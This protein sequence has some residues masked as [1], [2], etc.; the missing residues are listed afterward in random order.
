MK[1]LLFTLATLSGLSFNAFATNSGSTPIPPVPAQ[2]AADAAT[3]QA[4]NALL[5]VG[6]VQAAPVYVGSKSIQPLV[7]SG[8]PESQGILLSHSHILVQPLGD[9]NPS[10]AYEIAADN[11]F[12]TGYDQAQPK[13]LVPAPLA[14]LAAGQV[15]EA[16]GLTYSQ[17]PFKSG[18]VFNA[19]NGIHWVHANDQPINPG[20]TTNGWLKLVN[21]SGTT[22]E[23]LEGSAEYF[24]LWHSPSTNCNLPADA[25]LVPYAPHTFPIAKAGIFPW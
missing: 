20:H 9:S 6:T 8:K 24:C 25:P 7:D 2:Y 14:N 4:Q 16:C 17:T 18:S 21:Q 11:V 3:C 15:I 1:K 22:G 23:N 10:D 12:A 19:N 5:L 13:N